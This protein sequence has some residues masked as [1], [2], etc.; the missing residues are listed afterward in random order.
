M[1]TI[2]L[3]GAVWVGTRERSL[4]AGLRRA[5]F[6]FL[7]SGIFSMCFIVPNMMMTIFTDWSDRWRF[8]L[9]GAVVGLSLGP[10]VPQR[11]LRHLSIACWCFVFIVSRA[12]IACLYVPSVASS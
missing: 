9:S 4:A 10:H 6:I 11:T 8:S 5:P 1:P 12:I 2:T 7:G 3:L